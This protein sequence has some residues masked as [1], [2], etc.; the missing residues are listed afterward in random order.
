MKAA[1]MNHWETRSPSALPSAAVRSLAACRARRSAP[2]RTSSR[3]GDGRVKREG[4]WRARAVRL[5]SAMTPP[6]LMAAEVPGE[7][8]RISACACSRHARARRDLRRR[9]DR[10]A[11]PRGS[12]RGDRHGPGALAVGD[13]HRQRARRRAARLLRDPPP[14]AAA[15]RPLPPPLPGDRRLRRAHH[16]LDAPGRADPHARP[17]SR[18]PRARVRERQHRGGLRGGRPRHEPHPARPGGGLVVVWLGVAALGGAGAVARFA[19]DSAVSQRA[20]SGFPYGTLAVNVSGA[21]VLGLLAGGDVAGDALLLAGTATLGSYTTFSTWMLE[22]HR[23]GE[24]G[25]LGRMWLNLGGSLLAGLAFAA[26]G[27]ALGAAL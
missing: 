26:L 24:D 7:R 17:R 12:D 8:G 15:A 11:R 23:L 21:F 10:R 14:G 18:R 5:V 20:G 25:E 4:R 9:H 6:R 22:S 2:S 19:L 3:G 27:K 13:V 16:V 1:G